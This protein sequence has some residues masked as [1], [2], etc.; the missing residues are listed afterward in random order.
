M[1]ILRTRP[2]TF[3]EISRFK[4]PEMVP[5]CEVI[6]LICSPCISTCCNKWLL[7]Q[8]FASGLKLTFLLAL[9]ACEYD[10]SADEE[11]DVV[12]SRLIMWQHLCTVA[13]A[14]APM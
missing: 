2:G 11:G 5:Y 4:C 10:V 9:H 14:A 3:P 7:V 12:V 8:P 13:T 1:D 6:K